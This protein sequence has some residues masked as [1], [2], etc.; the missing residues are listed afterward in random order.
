ME[1]GSHATATATGFE[2]S[3][4]VQPLVALLMVAVAVALVTWETLDPVVAQPLAV[5]EI[6]I[7]SGLVPASVSGGV[8]VN[9][10]VRLVQVTLPVATVPPARVLGGTAAAADVVEVLV[11]GAFVLELVEEQPDSTTASARG[12][13]RANDMRP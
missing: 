7:V 3:R 9:M 6:W 10:P 12:R 11:V 1:L 4:L 13:A 5:S 8:K 2:V